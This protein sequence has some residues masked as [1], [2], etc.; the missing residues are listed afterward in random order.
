MREAP[1]L[2]IIDLLLQAGCKVK[3]YDPI[4]MEETKHKIG[5]VV[6][7]SQDMYDAAIDADALLIVTEWKQFRIPTWTVLQKVMRKKI[8]VDGRNLFKKSDMADLGFDYFS[9]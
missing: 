1:S 3:V 7:Y 2:V 5:D 6:E 9:I 4:A 8:I